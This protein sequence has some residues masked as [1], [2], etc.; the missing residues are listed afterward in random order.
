MDVATR[1]WHSWRMTTISPGS[2]TARIPSLVL[3]VEDNAIIAMNTEALLLDL[4]VE[5][6]KTAGS[7]AEALPLVEAAQFDLAILDMNLGDGETSLP[8][9]E[10]LH[11]AGVPIVFATG[12]GEALELP[13]IYERVA[14]LRKPYSFEDLERVLL[15]V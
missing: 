3:I 15:S 9:A 4:G 6:V 14:I 1:N 10:Q 2:Q 12:L 5:E 11:A 8:V 13:E 7:V